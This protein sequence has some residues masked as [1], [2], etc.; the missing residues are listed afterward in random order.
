MEIKNRLFPYP[1]LCEENDD[2]IDCS[3]SISM[4]L[5]EELKD[6]VFDL[7]VSIENNEELSWLVRDGKVNVIVHVECSN[8]S[9]RRLYTINGT[10]KTIR[11][12]KEKVNVEVALLGAIVANEGIK[13]YRNSKLN[14]D[15]SGEV[16]N[17][18]KGAILAYYNLPV[19]RVIKNY[20]ELKKDDAF[21][22]IVKMGSAD[23]Y[24]RRAISCDLN[25]P[26]IK[27]FV[28]ETTYN[29]YIKYHGNPMMEPLMH[30][31]IVLPALIY[32]LE[33]LRTVDFSGYK[34]RY[35]FQKISKACELNGKDFVE[36][37]I[38]DE[39]KSCV[40]WAQELLNMPISESFVGLS[41]ALED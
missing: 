20:E 21:F 11:I 1:V 7:D 2:Y 39:T 26:K 16:I 5:K 38:M 37:I 3:F 32:T 8:T 25:G 17:F 4:S 23:A 14:E 35:W 33:Q 6:L 13:K 15:Y 31:L 12:P 28:D 22:T 41:Y 24:A 36:D 30:S 29:E 18:P 19:V 34:S 27:I 9:F 40:E 10:K